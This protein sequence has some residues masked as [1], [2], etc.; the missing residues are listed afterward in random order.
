MTTHRN[1]NK[2]KRRFNLFGF[3]KTFI[4]IKPQRVM[5]A[6]RAAITL[7]GFDFPTLLNHCYKSLAK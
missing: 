1:P 4:A 5:E 7:W 3:Y 2:L 6:I